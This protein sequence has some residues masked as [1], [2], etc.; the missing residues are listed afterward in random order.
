MNNAGE[1][2]YD[3]LKDVN[4]LKRTTGEDEITAEEK[5]KKEFNFKNYAKMIFLTNELPETPDKT[6]AFYRRYYPII[7]PFAFTK[8]EADPLIIEKL[9][10][11]E[12][13]GLLYK[14]LYE[15]IPEF[16]GRGFRFSEDPDTD[17]LREMFEERSSPILQFIRS[18]C[19]EG[20]GLKVPKWVFKHMLNQW[21][22]ERGRGEWPD[23]RITR[24]MR[25]RGFEEGRVSYSQD[26]VVGYYEM[27]GWNVGD[28]E[29]EKKRWYSWKGL[30]FKENANTVNNEGLSINS[31][32]PV[33]RVQ[34]VC[35]RYIYIGKKTKPLD[36]LDTLDTPPSSDPFFSSC[37]EENLNEVE[38]KGKEFD[39]ITSQDDLDSVIKKICLFLKKN[40]DGTFR[41]KTMM[42]REEFQ[43][44]VLKSLKQHNLLTQGVSLTTLLTAINMVYTDHQE[45]M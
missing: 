26:E 19:V 24:W 33:Q 42:N 3:D 12:F 28:E 35:N 21:M 15:V 44:E 1:I 37:D 36:T 7:F 38:K 4:L 2:S 32:Y 27:L 6:D 29:V 11:K 5:F 31:A 22:R 8:D 45:Y 18:K 16:I 17:V 30:G 39:V 25:S 13:Q 43:K 40:G 14:C 23:E 41:N 34:G 20:P 9:S 10:D